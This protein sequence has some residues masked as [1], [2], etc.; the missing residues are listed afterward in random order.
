MFSCSIAFVVCKS[1]FWEIQVK[2][3]HHPISHYF[4]YDRS[5]RDCRN[6]RISVNL[7]VYLDSRILIF[8]WYFF[9]LSSLFCKSISNMMYSIKS[10]I[11]TTIDPYLNRIISI[12]ELQEERNHVLH[13][14][15]IGLMNTKNINLLSIPIRRSILTLLFKLQMFD[16]I[17]K[18]FSFFWRE[19]FRVIKFYKLV[20]YLCWFS[21]LDKESSNNN[22]TCPR[23]SSHLID[24]NKIVSDS[25]S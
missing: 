16:I 8:Y 1:V 18:D 13:T 23:P 7:V 25:S 6:K 9:L 19:L 5:C 14:L 21:Y 4:R 20:Q 24:A 2:F 12:H 3:T 10:I 11:V 22:W 17:K 15:T